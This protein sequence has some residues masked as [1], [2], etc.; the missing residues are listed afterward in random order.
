MM[1]LLLLIVFL[2]V[3]HYFSLSVIFGLLLIKSLLVVYLF[4]LHLA[5]IDLVFYLLLADI[6]LV[7]IVVSGLLNCTN[8][9]LLWLLGCFFYGVFLFHTFFLKFYVFNSIYNVLTF[10]CLSKILVSFVFVFAYNGLFLV[11]TFLLAYCVFINPGVVMM[12]VYFLSYTLSIFILFHLTGSI[13][14]SFYLIWVFQTLMMM[15]VLVWHPQLSTLVIYFAIPPALGFLLYVIALFSLSSWF[16]II[17][18]LIIIILYKRL[19]FLCMAL[20]W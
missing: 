4:Y 10:M 8:S 20:Y 13:F 1:I 15:S 9:L 12:C 14:S 7:I 18:F 19:F 2:S 11:I 3:S 16:A 5:N 17:L 6:F